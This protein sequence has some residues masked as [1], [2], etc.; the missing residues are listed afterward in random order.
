MDLSAPAT[1]SWAKGELGNVPSLAHGVHV[2]EV[3]HR[4]LEKGDV[5]MSALAPAADF[6]TDKSAQMTELNGR[7]KTMPLKV[8]EDELVHFEVV[9]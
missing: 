8:S 2:G 9:Q 1:R 7:F 3:A 5:S 4:A 6:I